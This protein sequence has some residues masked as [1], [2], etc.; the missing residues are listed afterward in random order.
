MILL[1]AQAQNEDDTWRNELLC[2]RAQLADY[3]QAQELLTLD[4]GVDIDRFA[5]D[6][7]YR[8]DSIL[9]LAMYV[10]SFTFSSFLPRLSQYLIVYFYRN[11]DSER[12]RF[13]L[14]LAARHSVDRGQVISEHV[15]NLVLSDLS[16]EEVKQRLSGSELTNILLEA[17]ETIKEK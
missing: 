3:V 5:S 10:S 14:A 17:S 13:A 2:W 16:L 12:L 15:A 7:Q 8:L 6:E 4:C 9:G 1:A 11:E